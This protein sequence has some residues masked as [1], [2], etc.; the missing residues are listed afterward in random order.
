MI[1]CPTTCAKYFK[2][3]YIYIKSLKSKMTSP[4]IDTICQLSVW[5]WLYL[6]R[7]PLTS[8]LGNQCVPMQ[9]Y[10]QVCLRTQFHP[11]Q[12]GAMFF[13]FQGID[14]AQPAGRQQL[15]VTSGCPATFFGTPHSF[16]KA[17]SIGTDDLWL[18][19]ICFCCANT[20]TQI[21]QM[22]KQ[23]RT[24][25]HSLPLLLLLPLFQYRPLRNPSLGFPK[26]Y[27]DCW[28]HSL[29]TWRKHN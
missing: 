20:A 2:N 29:K 24:R 26:R 8:A 23:V 5:W 19:N 7:T 6:S 3:I 28:N 13:S 16:R 21:L 11:V 27:K 1:I 4:T 9:E 12:I 17:W 18:K 25:H 22:P 14:S 15:Q 10:A